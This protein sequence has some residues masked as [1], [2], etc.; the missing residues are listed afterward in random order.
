M[1][2]GACAGVYQ[3]GEASESRRTKSLIKQW[4]VWQERRVAMRLERQAEPRK[5]G[6]PSEDWAVG[7]NPMGNGKPLG[8]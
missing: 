2:S 8:D 4:M 1:G 7:L 6:V 3:L 5:E